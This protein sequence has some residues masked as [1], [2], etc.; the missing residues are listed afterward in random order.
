MMKG[1]ARFN[2]CRSTP[3]ATRQGNQFALFYI[4][5]IGLHHFPF[6]KATTAQRIAAMLIAGPWALKFYDVS[7]NIL[8][9]D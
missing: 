6:M 5:R 2:F 8:S 9:I 7:Q 1:L 4:E 3:L